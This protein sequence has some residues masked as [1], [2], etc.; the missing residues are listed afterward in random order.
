MNRSHSVA[1]VADACAALCAMADR[2]AGREAG[3]ERRYLV[4]FGRAGAGIP[5]GPLWFV[6]A[7]A[8]GRNVFRG[9]GFRPELDDGSNGQARHFAG[10]VATAA[11]IGAPAT[12]WLS[13]HVRRDGLDT[14]DGRLTEVAL[15]FVT[16]IRSGDI[17][18][19]DASAWLRARLCA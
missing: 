1:G 16:G 4:E 13:V 15:E 7:G 2:L 17:T 14:A 9:R 19:A 3:A 10:I 5:S 11:R 6:A 12:R 8:G 18:P